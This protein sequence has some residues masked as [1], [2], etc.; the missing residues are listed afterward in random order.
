MPIS[1]TALER[2]LQLAKSELEQRTE[3]LTK[4][5][6][7]KA[8]LS[9]DPEWRKRNSAVKTVENRLRAVAATEANNAEV[10]RRK[11]EAEGADA[12]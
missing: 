12:E 5:G 11:A 7:E 10:E 8:Q 9:K 6:K 2:S 1:R 3:L 4:A